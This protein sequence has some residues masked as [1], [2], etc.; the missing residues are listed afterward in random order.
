MPV[1]PFY[2]Y[3]CPKDDGTT[4]IGR[5][6]RH[7]QVRVKE[8]KTAGQSPSAI[9]SHLAECDCSDAQDNFETFYRAN[10]NYEFSI[11]AAL[12]I[13]HHKPNLN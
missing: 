5:K 10:N 11:S 8:H 7:L 12:M 2:R 1:T 3:R 9:F 4:Y 6:E 13:A